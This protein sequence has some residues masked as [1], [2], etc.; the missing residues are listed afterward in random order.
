MTAKSAH[1]DMDAFAAI[2]K[3]MQEYDEKREV[4]I[5]ESRGAESIIH[6]TFRSAGCIVKSVNLAT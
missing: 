6:Q 3:S 1:V 2:N 4:V 5:K